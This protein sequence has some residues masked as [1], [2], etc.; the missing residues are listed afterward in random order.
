M[1]EMRNAYGILV[2]KLKGSGFIC[3]RIR[4][5]GPFLSKVSKM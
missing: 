3:L 1:H 4:T 2:G 5:S